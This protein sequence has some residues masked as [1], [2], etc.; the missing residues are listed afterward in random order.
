MVYI[1]VL[2]QEKDKYYIGKTDNPKLDETQWKVR[3]KPSIIHQMIPDQTDDDEERIIQEYKD[4]YGNDNVHVNCDE[5]DEEEIRSEELVP[6]EEQKK[7]EE[8]DDIRGEIYTYA[9]SKLENSAY[10]YAFSPNIF[11]QIMAFI[12]Q[13]LQVALY[14]GIAHICSSEYAEIDPERDPM[15]MSMLL[16]VC[17]QITIMFIM[18]EAMTCFSTC[19]GVPGCCGVV[20][21][22]EDINEGITEDITE[23]EH[24]KGIRYIMKKFYNSEGPIS[25]KISISL[26]FMLIIMRVLAGIYATYTLLMYECSTPLDYFM[27]CIAVLFVND[28]DETLGNIADMAS[29]KKK[30][31]MG[32]PALAIAALFAYILILST[33][34]VNYAVGNI[35]FT[36]CIHPEDENGTDVMALLNN[37]CKNGEERLAGYVC[38]TDPFTELFNSNSKRICTTRA[39]LQSGRLYDISSESGSSSETDQSMSYGLTE[40][41]LNIW[42]WMFIISYLSMIIPLINIIIFQKKEVWKKVCDRIRKESDTPNNP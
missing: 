24:V 8:T 12:I 32:A 35:R 30:D 25:T 17:F 27:N 39:P 36:S 13:S 29:K 15:D 14:F 7:E 34:A 41:Q 4:K 22:S 1:Y 28:M 20:E 11:E 5:E 6:V 9:A 21:G 10:K 26:F 42:L 40:G 18:N 3:Y 16:F 33:F 2:K 19:A 37:V 31:V 38:R 23:E